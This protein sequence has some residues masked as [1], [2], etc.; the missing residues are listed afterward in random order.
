MVPQ[1]LLVQD[2]R[3]KLKKVVI[4]RESWF[5]TP[6]SKDLYIHLIGDFDTAGQC[7]VNDSHNMIILHPDHLVSATVVA[8]SIGCQRRAV[9]QDRIKKNSGDLGKPQVFGNIFHEIF[10]EALKLNQ[11]D[12][13]TL[14]TMTESVAVKHIEEIYLIHMSIPE[15]V[16]YVMSKI[17]ALKSW[18]ELFL[19]SKPSVSQ[20]VMTFNERLSLTF[21]AE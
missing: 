12:M 2:E 21:C 7:V 9:L 19:R 6:C 18:A 8:D 16:D 15:A 20:S 3:S 17:P 13:T 11:W 5:D 4:L 10:Q 1:V 14:R